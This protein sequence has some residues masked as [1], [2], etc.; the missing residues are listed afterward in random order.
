MKDVFHLRVVR[1][2]QKAL[3]FQRQPEFPATS[4]T[5][6][7]TTPPHKSLKKTLAEIKGRISIRI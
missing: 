3:V 2:E 6:N 4:P 1:G 5:G 7:L